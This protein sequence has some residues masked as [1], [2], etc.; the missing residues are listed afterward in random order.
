M[1]EHYQTNG[2]EVWT[3]GGCRELVTVYDEHDTLRDGGELEEAHVDGDGLDGPPER[4]PYRGR[5]A[6]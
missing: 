3:C 6:S 1:A 5:E 4:F 2:W